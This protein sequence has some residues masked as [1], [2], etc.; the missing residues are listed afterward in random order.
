MI[1]VFHQFCFLKKNRNTLAPEMKFIFQ[2]CLTGH[3]NPRTG[4]VR[5]GKRRSN[6][7]AM[8]RW[9]WAEEDT[10]HPLANR[11]QHTHTHRRR[12]DR[13]GS[14][15]ESKS[16]GEGQGQAKGA[17]RK[18]PRKQ[19]NTLAVTSFCGSGRGTRAPM[20]EPGPVG[21]GGGGGTARPGSPAQQSTPV[22]LQ[23]YR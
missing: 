21:Q 5:S 20:G 7:C 12:A 13:G 22:L 6:G 17:G 15:R 3:G 8:K 10:L 1:C 18:P 11:P 4:E 2:G 9:V 19:V 16:G 14:H 23:E